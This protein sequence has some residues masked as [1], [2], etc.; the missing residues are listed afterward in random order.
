MYPHADFWP[1]DPEIVSAIKADFQGPWGDRRQEIVFIGEKIDKEGLKAIFDECLLTEME[2]KRWTK[3]M[4]KGVSK[5]GKF[6]VVST[7]EGLN[8]LF[9]DGWEDWP[10]PEGYEEEIGVEVP[11]RHNNHNHTHI[12]KHATKSTKMASPK[13]K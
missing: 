4:E 6:D 11:D 5:A 9:E 8:R 12:H 1:Q 3:V 2:Y 13:L 7:M 10:V